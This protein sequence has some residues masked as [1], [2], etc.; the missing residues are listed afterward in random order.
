MLGSKQVSDKMEAFFS[1]YKTVSRL[2][3]WISWL[4]HLLY[5]PGDLNLVPRTHLK[6]E[7]EN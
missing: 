2:V 7:G 6:M 1:E 3:N 5:E 4:R